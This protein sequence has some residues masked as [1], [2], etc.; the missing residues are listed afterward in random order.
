MRGG[1]AQ[2]LSQ[3]KMTEVYAAAEQ[4]EQFQHA[5]CTGMPYR[6]RSELS[7]GPHFFLSS[8]FGLQASDRKR[9]EG[10]VFKK[11]RTDR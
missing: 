3:H 5:A 11:L 7:C 9:N 2:S 10:L 8:L 6:G 4:I 1:E